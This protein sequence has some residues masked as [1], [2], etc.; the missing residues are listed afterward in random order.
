LVQAHF[1]GRQA[2]NGERRENGGGLQVQMPD[3]ATRLVTV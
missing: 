3:R 1:S 2:T